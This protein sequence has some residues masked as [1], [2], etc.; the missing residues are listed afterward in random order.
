M[1]ATS[2]AAFGCYGVVA[3]VTIAFGLIYLLRPSFMPYHQEA[4]AR[5][6][7]ELEPRLQAL[8]LAFLRAAGGG[9]LAS[10]I[11]AGAMLL[12][13]FRAGEGWSLVAI[14]AVELA[15]VLPMLWATYIVRS[16]TGA[17]SPVWLSAAGIALVVAG[18]ALA[19]V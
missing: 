10:G 17:H 18:I 1:S 13:P 6:W 5:P 7:Q 16:R 3:L 2:I 8:L 19:V 14:P 15:V 9:M 11:G 4:L 12:V